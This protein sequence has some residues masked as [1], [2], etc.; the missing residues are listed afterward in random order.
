[1][2]GTQ[3]KRRRK[4]DKRRGAAVVEAAVCGGIIVTLTF[5]TLEVCS[6]IYLKESVTVA[7]YE[8][9]RVGVKRKATFQDAKS[10]AES[11][12]ES[13]GVKSGIITISPSDFSS[14][15]ALDPITVVVRAPV[16]KNGFFIG[17]FMSNKKMRGRLS[18]YRE[19]DE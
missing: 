3:K 1:M 7:A 5:A 2:L 18:M 11:I 6:S 14:L 16:S 19:F 8:A 10:Q 15:K 9:A 4:S 17:K 12:L 13:R